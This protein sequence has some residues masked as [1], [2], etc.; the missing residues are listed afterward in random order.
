MRPHLANLQQARVMAEYYQEQVHGM[1]LWIGLGVGLLLGVA[2]ERLMHY[3]PESYWQMYLC[4]AWIPVYLGG[5]LAKT[6]LQD[7]IG[8]RLQAR[9][10]GLQPHEETSP[11]VVG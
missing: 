7:R 9:L 1:C 10:S 4:V 2:A 3:L 11:S 6:R 8:T 5:W